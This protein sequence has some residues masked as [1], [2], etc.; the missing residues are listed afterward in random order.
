MAGQIFRKVALERLS[1]PEQLDQLMRITTPKGWVALI[2]IGVL[3]ACAVLWGIWG[4]IPDKI[5]GQGI[6]MKSGGVFNIVSNSTGRVQ[7][8]YFDVDDIVYRGQ[9]VAR[10]EQPQVLDQIKSARAKLQELVE[11]RDRI[12]KFGT[13]EMKLEGES[14]VQQRQSLRRT[15]TNLEERIKWLKKKI[16]NQKVIVEKGLITKQQLINTQE[17]LS[18]TRQN[19]R[20]NRTKLQQLSIKKVQLTNQQKEELAAIEQKINEAGRELEQLQD[21]LNETAKVASPYTGR[22]LEV[23]VDEG[24]LI[25]RGKPLMSIELM[26]KEIK[27]LEAVLY[28]PPRDGKKIRLGMAAQVAPSTVKQERYGFIKGMVTYV[29]EFPSTTQGMMRVLQN[30]ELIR[31][32]SMGAAPIEVRADLIPDHRTPSGYK[33]SSSKGPPIEIHTGTLCTTTVI[34]SEQPPYNLVIPLFKKYLLGIGK[35]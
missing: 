2:S 16:E 17:E 23:S 35:K 22:I 11:E 6:L 13:E 21:E 28:F 30:E 32:L 9:V 18:S 33:W 15:I 1:S 8:L 10:L 24:T 5:M 19:I 3:L 20:E 29:S 26:G 4:T 31:T 12:T 25:N 7:N 27:S 14:M 34:V